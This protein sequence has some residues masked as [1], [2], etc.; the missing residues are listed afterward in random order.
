MFVD[1][2]LFK[3]VLCGLVI[4]WNLHSRILGKLNS[5]M[6]ESTPQVVVI[7]NRTTRR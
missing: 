5:T 4:R 1:K 2:V 3:H 7:G 6:I